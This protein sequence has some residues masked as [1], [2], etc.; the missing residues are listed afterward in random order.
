MINEFTEEKF[1]LIETSLEMALKHFKKA[2]CAWGLALT[3][4]Q[5]GVLKSSSVYIAE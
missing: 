2:Q 1:D 3:Y 5:F 4:F